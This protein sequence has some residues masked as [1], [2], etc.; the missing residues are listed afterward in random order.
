MRKKTI[1]LL[2]LFL[3]VLCFTGCSG[4]TSKKLEEKETI[5]KEEIGLPKYTREQLEL[6]NIYIKNGDNYY[7][8]LTEFDSRLEGN[9]I[10]NKDRKIFLTDNDILVPTLYNNDTLIYYSDQ[11]VL[12][13]YNFEYFNDEGYTIGLFDIFPSTDISSKY[14][15]KNSLDNIIYGSDFNN[16]MVN[17]GEDTVFFLSKFNGKEITSIPLT[18]SGTISGLTYGKTYSIEYYLGTQ[19]Y[20]NKV[21][22]DIHA[23]V[24]TDNFT[25]KKVTLTEESFLEIIPPDLDNGYYLIDSTYLIK[26]YNGNR[27]DGIAEEKSNKEEITEEKQKK[28]EKEDVNKEESE[29][30]EEVK[31]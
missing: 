21:K 7:K 20:K 11:N 4:L 6:G 9:G 27:A 13:E 10:Y 29:K 23:F 16:L 28:T 8:A 18:R 24:S 17:F 19:Y 30:K 12:G 2:F 5:E 22:A 15:F 31:K 1:T 3:I 14:I 26:R 25:T